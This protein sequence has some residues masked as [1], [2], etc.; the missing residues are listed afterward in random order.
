MAT[1]AERLLSTTVENVLAATPEILLVLQIARVF[2]EEQLL[3][4]TAETA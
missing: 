1:G 3:W 4:I 2:P